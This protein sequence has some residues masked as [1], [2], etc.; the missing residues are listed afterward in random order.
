MRIIML[1][2]HMDSRYTCKNGLKSSKPSSKKAKK[3][4]RRYKR[5]KTS[6][7]H[8]TTKNHNYYIRVHLGF[9]DGNNVLLNGGAH[10]CKMGSIVSK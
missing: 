6:D 9:I 2:G 4:Q 1:M 7:T 3:K 5:R 10:I 8:A